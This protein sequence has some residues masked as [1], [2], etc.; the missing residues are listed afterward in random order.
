MIELGLVNTDLE[1]ERE[2]IYEGSADG[3]A[4]TLGLELFVGET[5][6]GKLEVGEAEV[7]AKGTAYG[8]S[9]ENFHILSREVI[10]VTLQ[11]ILNEIFWKIQIWRWSV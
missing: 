5:E 3:I 8:K 2:E 1:E 7:D 9:C 11:S 10:Q 6:R 4:V